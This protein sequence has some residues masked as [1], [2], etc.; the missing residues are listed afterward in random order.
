MCAHK[1]W[2][3][4]MENIFGSK[5][6]SSGANAK[7]LVS[8]VWLRWLFEADFSEKINAANGHEQM[9]GKFYP[10]SF[11][12]LFACG[13]ALLLLLLLLLCS[14]SKVP[15]I[16]AKYVHV[17]LGLCDAYTPNTHT[18]RHKYRRQRNGYIAGDQKPIKYKNVRSPETFA[19]DT[20]ET[21]QQRNEGNI[22]Q[23]ESHTHTQAGLYENKFSPFQI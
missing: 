2:P 11:R 23:R 13:F 17:A 12:V 18:H 9:G 14:L 15:L 22:S 19:V 16:T 7:Q 5:V 21:N 6:V 4:S 1:Q 20:K 10:Q 8:R 3:L